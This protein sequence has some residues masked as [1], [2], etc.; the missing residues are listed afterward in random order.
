MIACTNLLYVSLS[1]HAHILRLCMQALGELYIC[2]Y[3]HGCTLAS[4]SHLLGENG[5]NF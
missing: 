3:M 2:M 4:D 5:I 1:M